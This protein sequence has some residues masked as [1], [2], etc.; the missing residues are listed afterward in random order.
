MNE[1]AITQVTSYQ[2]QKRAHCLSST[3]SVLWVLHDIK[4]ASASGFPEWKIIRLLLA[5]SSPPLTRRF[6]ESPEAVSRSCPADKNTRVCT[7]IS[8]PLDDIARLQ[9]ATHVQYDGGRLLSARLQ[10]TR[11]LTNSNST[12][13]KA[14]SRIWR[15]YSLSPLLQQH[16]VG[17]KALGGLES[18]PIMRFM[19]AKSNTQQV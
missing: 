18:P 1:T 3:Y 7:S 11:L 5:T 16:R 15:H 6:L 8:R 12:R 10:I 4:D 9:D 13:S 19:T 14:P 17:T 2:S